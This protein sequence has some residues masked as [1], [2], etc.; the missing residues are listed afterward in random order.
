MS[1]VDLRDH[2]QQIL[3]AIA[4]DLSAPQARQAQIGKSKGLTHESDQAPETAAQSHA[5]LRARHSCDINQLSAEYRALRAVALRLWLDEGGAEPPGLDDIVSFNEAID[6]APTESVRF[7]SSHR[8]TGH[9][10]PSEYA[11][12]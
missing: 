8:W 3:E 10:T 12:A 11:R 9:A 6:Q 5:M 7:F 2:A 1:S 4:R